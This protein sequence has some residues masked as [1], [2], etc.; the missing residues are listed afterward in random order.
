MFS[1]RGDYKGPSYLNVFLEAK[2][3]E[4]VKNYLAFFGFAVDRD[5]RI[6]GSE[7]IAGKLQNQWM[8]CQRQQNTEKDGP[9]RYQQY[10]KSLSC[11][12]EKKKL[13]G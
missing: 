6:V 10:S 2:F 4:P 8:Y 7:K 5:H 1:C 12:V 13:D 9:F 3:L 11:H